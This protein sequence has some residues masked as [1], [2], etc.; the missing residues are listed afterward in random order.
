MPLE[1][2]MKLESLLALMERLDEQPHLAPAF[3]A[4]TM[5]IDGSMR[6]WPDCRSEAL[7]LLPADQAAAMDLP[8]SSFSLA[9]ECLEDMTHFTNLRH[10]CRLAIFEHFR[11]MLQ[12]VYAC[13]PEDLEK[14]ADLPISFL[15]GSRTTNQVYHCDFNGSAH[16]TFQRLHA[17]V[18][19]SPR[20]TPSTQFLIETDPDTTTRAFVDHDQRIPYARACVGSWS[21]LGTDPLTG[22]A[23]VAD[24]EMLSAIPEL[25]DAFARMRPFIT[26]L[27]HRYD[28][29]GIPPAPTSRRRAPKVPEPAVN[30][31]RADADRQE[32]RSAHESKQG[33]STLFFGSLFHNGLR[34]LGRKRF[35]FWGGASVSYT[36]LTLPTI[37]SV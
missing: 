27:E 16:V 5:Q 35:A 30:S 28:G 11:P 13:S 15:T 26:A 32:Q 18:N 8:T 6:D 22:R 24:P 31:E 7:R 21:L 3:A 29:S 14:A 19:I 12:T 25:K 34:S 10:E 37:Y 36:H 23:M 2:V 1:T 20:P 33:D 9:W 17:T 4:K